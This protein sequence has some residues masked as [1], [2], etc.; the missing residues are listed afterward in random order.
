MGEAGPRGS[1]LETECPHWPELLW[2]DGKERALS[3]RRPQLEAE[4][5]HWKELLRQD[6]KEKG[7][8]YEKYLL[9]AKCPHWPELLRQGKWHFFTGWGWM[10]G[11]WRPYWRQSALTGQNLFEEM[12]RKM[13]FFG[14]SLLETEC[15]YWPELLWQDGKEDGAFYEKVPT[16]NRVHLLARTSLTRW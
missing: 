14:S 3:L 11:P 12:V 16:G 6:G 2:Q 9:E 15:P 10:P 1:L 5:P 8:F 13:A 4:C 7:T